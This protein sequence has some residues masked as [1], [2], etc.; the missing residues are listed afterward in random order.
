M[1]KISAIAL[2]LICFFPFAAGAEETRK[3]DGF[4]YIFEIG[5]KEPPGYSDVNATYYSPYNSNSALYN[6]SD[7]A[8]FESRV[9]EFKGKTV[10]E[11]LDFVRYCY[12][13][14]GRL[15]DYDVAS[16]AVPR[17]KKSPGDVINL[18][19]DYPG[20]QLDIQGS[21]IVCSQASTFTKWL[22][23]EKFN[24]PAESVSVSSGV[25]HNVTVAWVNGR[26]YILDWQNMHDTGEAKLD[27]AMQVYERLKGVSLTRI[28][29]SD[30]VLEG[31][32][33]T[34]AYETLYEETTGNRSMTE[35]HLAMSVQTPRHER[36]LI[37]RADKLSHSIDLNYKWLTLGVSHRSYEDPANS[38]DELFNFKAGLRFKP[39]RRNTLGMDYSYSMLWNKLAADPDERRRYNS[40]RGS[41]FHNYLYAY[42]FKKS[43]S[44]VFATLSNEIYASG[45]S[46]AKQNTVGFSDAEYEIHYGL[47][48]RYESDSARCVIEGGGGIVPGG[49]KDN[50]S[51]ELLNGVRYARASLSREF[52]PA[53]VS[54]S[55]FWAGYFGMWAEVRESLSVE[56]PFGTLSGERRYKID[57]SDYDNLVDENERLAVS[58]VSPV[59]WRGARIRLGYEDLA[60]AGEAGYSGSVDFRF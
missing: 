28:F 8:S 14:M 51:F 1:K 55:V 46:D 12:K 54:A 32:I 5:H 11:Q 56:T 45:Y 18:I 20:S 52:G 23:E 24:I 21:G 13:E 50:G 22:L 53:A 2:F 48:Y 58:Y 38:I 17:E 4:E 29:D 44:S 43:N 25:P 59:L 40:F 36:S 16:F 15:Y 10:M 30:A 27:R 19:A 41:L 39:G 3:E 6:F 9:N 42:P 57:D 60:G 35:R 31:Y 47:G 7:S 33:R 34:R 37:V 49:N 26:H